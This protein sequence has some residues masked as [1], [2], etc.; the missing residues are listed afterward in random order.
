MQFVR[1]C[2]IKEQDLLK[3]GLK[4]LSYV[5]AIATIHDTHP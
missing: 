5:L 2:M 1:E 3:K 4:K